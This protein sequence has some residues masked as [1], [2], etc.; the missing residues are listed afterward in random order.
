M[1]DLERSEKPGEAHV[2]GLAGVTVGLGASVRW[3]VG[4]GAVRPDDAARACRHRALLLWPRL[5]ASR[6]ARTRG[7]PWRIARLVAAR[8]PWPLEDI[9]AM[10]T[11]SAPACPVTPSRSR[12]P[13][14]GTTRAGAGG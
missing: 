2:G 11:R 10:V 5:D 4:E 7:D 12:R 1:T 9:V 14:S 13:A 6:L 3:E 8:T